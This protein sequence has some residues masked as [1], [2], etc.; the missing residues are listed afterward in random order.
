VHV[1]RDLFASRMQTMTALRLISGRLADLRPPGANPAFTQRYAVA[2][3]EDCGT[4]RT[5]DLAKPGEHPDLPYDPFNYD[6][7][8]EE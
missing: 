3:D 8:A 2:L 5:Y 6:P 1:G 4:L 7:A